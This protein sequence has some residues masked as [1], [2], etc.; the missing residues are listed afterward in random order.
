MI[1][2]LGIAA[3][4]ISVSFV[5]F[6]IF[7]GWVS[8]FTV[9]VFLVE[10]SLGGF[11]NTDE[12]IEESAVRDV[13][14]EVVLE[15]LKIVHDVLNTLV[16]SNSWEG[17]S[18]VIELPGM[19]LWGFGLEFTGDL[20]SILVVDLVEVSGEHVHL[21][22]HLFSRNFECWFAISGSQRLDVVMLLG[23]VMMVGFDL[24]GRCFGHKTNAK[25]GNNLILHYFY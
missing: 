19:D 9:V 24:G 5:L 1:Y 21:V 25:E 14:V 20:D 8:E 4:L 12:S 13:S 22:R 6:W 3:L 2:T 16:S 10:N 18:G 17:E 23:V 7:K 11:T 15:V